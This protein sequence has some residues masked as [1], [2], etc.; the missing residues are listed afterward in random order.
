MD[1]VGNDRNRSGNGRR[2]K[3]KDQGETN[4]LRH[5][6]VN[7]TIV[8][9]KSTNHF[10][11]SNFDDMINLGWFAVHLAALATPWAAVAVSWAII[12]GKGPSIKAFEHPWALWGPLKRRWLTFGVHLLIERR[13]T[14]RCRNRSR[15]S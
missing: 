10:R 11:I 15:Q 6:N 13:Q 2:R 1:R 14:N 8:K 5:P 4:P 7:L 3:G 9:S 12:S